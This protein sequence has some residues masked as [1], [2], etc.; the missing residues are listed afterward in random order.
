[1]KSSDAFSYSM[2]VK[3]SQFT[4]AS[5]KCSSESP[6]KKS[7]QVRV[8]IIINLLSGALKDLI[9]VSSWGLLFAC[10]TKWSNSDM[11]YLSHNIFAQM[12]SL[13]S[14]NGEVELPNKNA[15]VGVAEHLL[16]H[17]YILFANRFILDILCI[18]LM[19]VP[20]GACLLSWLPIPNQ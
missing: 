2:E 6:Y 17:V 15:L 20:V 9:Q 1:M 16:K 12:L 11:I 5:C 10:L 3:P 18:T 4:S 13:N 8:F 14:G 19:I 7:V